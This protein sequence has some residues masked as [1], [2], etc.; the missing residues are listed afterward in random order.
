ME[1]DDD[2]KSTKGYDKILE[3]IANTDG[4][5]SMTAT[6]KRLR[7][8]FHKYVKQEV[9]KEVN[10]DA[11]VLR[12]MRREHREND[13]GDFRRF[14]VISAPT[15]NSKSLAPRPQVGRQVTET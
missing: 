13:N 2:A 1:K 14:S 6:Q 5:T 7:N 15:F 9:K 8:A 12:I 11:E 4:D 3:K 10:D